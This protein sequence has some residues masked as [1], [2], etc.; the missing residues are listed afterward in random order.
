MNAAENIERLI[1]KFYEAEKSSATTSA[2][3]DKRVLDDVLVAYEKSKKA[4]TAVKQPLIWRIIMNRPVTKIAA[5]VII[6]AAVL[7]ITFFDKLTT[8]AYAIEQTI[9]ANHSVR[10]LYIKD[11]KAGE[12][13]PKQFWVEFYENGQVKN[14]RMDFPEWAS[15]GDGPK[16]VVWKENKAQVWF[17]KKKSFFTVLDKTVAD[18]FLKMIEELDPKRAVERLYEREKQGKVNIEIDEPSDKTKPIVVTATYLPESSTPGKRGVLF[19]DQ[20]TKLVTAIEFYQLTNG[21][22]KQLGL[23]EFYDYN[24]P[25]QSKMFVLDSE[26]PPDVMRV[27]QTTQDIGLVQGQLSDE[28]IAVEVVRQFFEALIA[29]DYAKAGKLME[30][31]PA[32]KMRE[33]FSDR[34]FLGIVSI[35]LVA[36]HPIP[37]TKGVI[38][39]CTVE[40]EK[41]GQKDQWKLDTIG[42]RQVYN[43]PGRWTIFGGI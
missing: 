27:D 15:G 2:E 20:A 31:I 13:E 5:A 28:E 18:H 33:G 9:K 29:G 11:F 23:M 26:I 7:S 21:K 41:D 12:D 6:V 8:T 1:K 10:Y 16:V 25:I 19:V 39:P 37:E 32:D 42:V 35:G 22:Y 3:M 4:K 43:Q 40:F 36:P 30:G 17:K 38:V 34:K 24:K 14:V